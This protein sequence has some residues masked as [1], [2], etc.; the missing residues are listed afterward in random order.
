VLDRACQGRPDRP[1]WTSAISESRTCWLGVAC[2]AVSVSVE[3]VRIVTDHVE[4]LRADLGAVQVRRVRRDARSGVRRVA[5]PTAASTAG[6]RRWGRLRFG[7]GQ[8]LSEAG[9]EAPQSSV[10]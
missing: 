1:G 3:A 4:P 8:W 9:A 5:V 10:G 6:L 7:L 2:D